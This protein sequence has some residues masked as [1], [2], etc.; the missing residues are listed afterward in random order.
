LLNLILCK[1]RKGD[2][3]VASTKESPVKLHHQQLSL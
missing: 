2:H 3:I 1:S